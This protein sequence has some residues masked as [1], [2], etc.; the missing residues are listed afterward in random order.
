LPAVQSLE[1][2]HPPAACIVDGSFLAERSAF[3][4]RVSGDERSAASKAAFVI[5]AG[6]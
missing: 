2:E 4:G 3:A 1:V 5:V 6:S